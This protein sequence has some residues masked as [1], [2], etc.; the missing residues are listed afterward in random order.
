MGQ[1]GWASQPPDSPPFP[2]FSPVP[3]AALPVIHKHHCVIDSRSRRNAGFLKELDPLGSGWGVG[4]WTGLIIHI[5][6]LREEKQ[7]TT[8]AAAPAN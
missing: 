3:S 8:T 5:T 6:L 1:G 4:A 7:Q 2:R